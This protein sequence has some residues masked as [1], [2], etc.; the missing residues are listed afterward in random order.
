[1]SPDSEMDRT[2]Q[3]LDEIVRLLAL[4]VRNG[5]ESQTAAITLLSDAGLEPNRI[6][7]LVGTTPATV[8]S[9]QARA[10]SK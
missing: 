10:R 6:A 3:L 9:A 2:N 7:E 8:R 5:A 4:E 1:M